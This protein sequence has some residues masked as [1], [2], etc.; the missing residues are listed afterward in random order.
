VSARIQRQLRSVSDQ[1]RT[2]DV[3][4]VAVYQIGSGKQRAV[5]QARGRDIRAA[6]AKINPNARVIVRAYPARN[7]APQCARYQNRCGL[8]SLERNALVAARN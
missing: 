4:R 2:A 7:K 3:I 8:I 1:I 6:I 5:A